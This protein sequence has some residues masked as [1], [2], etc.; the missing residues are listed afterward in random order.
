MR[1]Q[2]GGHTASSEASDPAMDSGEDAATD[3]ETDRGGINMAICEGYVTRLRAD[4][5]PIG[6][7]CGYHCYLDSVPIGS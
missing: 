5:A 3:S 1:A 7:R 2:W 4:R 6:P